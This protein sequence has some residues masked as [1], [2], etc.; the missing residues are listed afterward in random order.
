M[1]PSALLRL[2]RGEADGE[3]LPDEPVAHGGAVISSAYLDEARARQQAE[4]FWAGR[5]RAA[6]KSA[7]IAA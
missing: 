3:Y 1:G 5:N 6:R 2:L 7:R 4:L